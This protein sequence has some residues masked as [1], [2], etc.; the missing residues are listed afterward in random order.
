MEKMNRKNIWFVAL[1]IAFILLIVLIFL[2]NKPIMQNLSLVPVPDVTS[3]NQSIYGFED[4]QWWE[5]AVFY[6]IFVRSFNDSNGD[7]IGDFAGLTSKLDYLNDGDPSTDTDLGITAIWL[8]PIFPSPSYHG[9]DVT[10]YYSINPDYGTMEDF[11]LF[12]NEAHKRGIHVILD[13]VINHTSVE[14]PWFVNSLD[15]NNEY[16]DWY[17]WSESNPGYKGPWGQ[18]VWFPSSG[19]F[20]YSVFWQGMPDL[21]YRNANVTAEMNK[22]ASY[23]INDIGVDGFRIDGAK[24][25]IED[26]KIQAN[27][28]ETIAWFQ[29]FYDLYKGWNAKAMTVGEVWDSSNNITTYLES[30]SFDMVFNF[31]LAGDIISMVNSG[32]ANSL[33]SSITTESYLFQ[34]YTMGTFLT[35]HDMDRVMSQLNNNQDFAKNAATILLTSPGTPFIYYGEEIGMTGEKPD[36]KIRTPMQWTGED[37][38]GFTTGKPW[39]SI[40]SNYP[41]V[42]V[43][44]ESVDPQ[45]LLSHYR[46]LNRIRLTNSALLEGKF[47]K[48]NVSSP[49]LFAG[50]RA[51]DLEAVLTI[52]NL[53]NTEVENPTFSFKKDLNP[54]LYNV[55][56]LLGDKPFS[57]SINLVQVGE[58]ID[59]SLPIT[60]MPYENLIIKLIPIN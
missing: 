28:K 31:D 12:L 21:N 15:I 36:E 20:Y 32:Q 4:P 9:Y 58:K 37:L 23:W 43:A 48:V 57:E 56:L 24:H 29:S 54:G 55:D 40:N 50:L 1:V 33:G 6:E 46:D 5:H 19:M 47:I 39:Q 10:D 8:M 14:H 59:F 44:L 35:N 38:A 30:E 49:Q 18:D 3:N 7:G 53:K 22:A 25:L 34:G 45:S 52:V 17:I 41:E 26:E 51:E 27:S 13:F 2:L 42:N 60:V 16:R 11:N